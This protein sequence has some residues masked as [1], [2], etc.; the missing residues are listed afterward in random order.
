MGVER[1]NYGAFHYLLFLCH[2]YVLTL[3]QFHIEPL[4]LHY[5]LQYT[6]LC[7]L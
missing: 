2:W 4:K 3:S 1:N 6:L 7:Y 5:I